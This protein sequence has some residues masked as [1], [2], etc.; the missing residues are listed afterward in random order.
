MDELSDALAN[1]FTDQVF[2]RDAH[3]MPGAVEAG[4]VPPDLDR[5]HQPTP[6]KSG[7][8]QELTE[9]FAN[10]TTHPK[11][12][13][14]H[15]INCHDTAENVYE[16]ASSDEPVHLLTP[17]QVKARPSRIHRRRA[18]TNIGMGTQSE[19][20]QEYIDKKKNLRRIHHKTTKENNKSES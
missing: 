20:S 18:P 7:L 11:S 6:R 9:L 3:R 13:S 15:P 14:L 2:L 10:P 16:N 4:I 12:A 19:P 8:T 5:R 1:C 17:E